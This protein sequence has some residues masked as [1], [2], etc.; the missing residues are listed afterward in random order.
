[1]LKRIIAITLIL[2]CTSIAWFILAGTITWRTYQSDARLK[3]GVASVWGAAQEQRPPAASYVKVEQEKSETE[4]DGHKTVRTAMRRTTICLPPENSRINVNLALDYRQKGLLWYSTYVVDFAGVYIFR[5]PTSE[6]QFV[7]FHLRF[8]AEQAIYDG[9]VMEVNGRPVPLITDKHEAFVA[10]PLSPDATA[11]LRVVYRSQGLQSW[12]YKLNDDIA[13]SRDFQLSMKTNFKPID[14]PPDTLSPTEKRETAT[15]WDLTWR[16]KNRISGLQIGMAMPEK[17]QPGPLAGEISYF[18]PV[19]LLLFFFLIFII[20]TV[21]NIDL[22]PMNY[23]FLATAF[24]AFHL[25]FAYLVDHIS[26][27]IAF[28]ICSVVS[29]F[30]VVSYLRLVVGLRFAIIE[31]GTAQ[32]IYLVLFS[33]AF[34]INGFSALTVTIGCIVT[35][36]IVMQ[37]TARIR[38]AE[39]FARNTGACQP[40]H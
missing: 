34:F 39:K 11:T 5:N 8:P 20:T 18:A 12:R 10:A 21:R 38:W 26:I 15:G 35:L 2:G 28:I 23:F 13:Q 4:T 29:V 1:M 7:T 32:M 33:Y 6:T 24:F 25:L 17:L 3:P 19:S 37:M 30:L 36:F 31:A 9:L 40:I 16:Y 22:H 14:F 27:H